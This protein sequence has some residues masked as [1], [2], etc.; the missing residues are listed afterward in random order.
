MAGK[1]SIAL[2]LIF[3]A[4]TIPYISLLGVLTDSPAE[5]LSANGYRLFFAKIAAFLVTIIVPVLAASWGA[6]HIARGY[7]LAMSVMAIAAAAL[8]LFCVPATTERLQQ[9][10]ERKPFARQGRLLVRNARPLW[11]VCGR[12][13]RVCR[14][15]RDRG[16]L[17]QV[18]PGRRRGAVVTGSRHRRRGG[19]SRC[20][21]L[22][23]QTPLPS[24][25]TSK[26]SARVTPHAASRRTPAGA[27]RGS[28][29]SRPGPGLPTTRR[30]GWC[31][32]G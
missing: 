32:P 24:I 12:H 5:R 3:T 22:D 10:V 16:V 28:G 1:C 26:R 31:R 8:F 20:V 27:R 11:R 4:V 29:S 30:A 18:R 19:S 15:R 9:E 14:A 25:A 21:H 7:Q 23:H 17:R 6:G 13:D 2:T